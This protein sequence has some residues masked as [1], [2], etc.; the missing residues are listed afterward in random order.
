MVTIRSVNEIIQSLQDFFRLVQ[1]NLDTK[2]GTVARDLFIE[3]PASQ[4]SLLYDELSGVS[5]QQSLRLVIGSDLDRLAKNFG[6][7]RKQSTP[8]TGTALLTFTSIPANIAINQG[9]LVIANNGISFAVTA[10]IAITPA[11]SN[12]YKSVASKFSSQLSTAGITDQYAVQVTVIATS[13]GSSGNIGIYSLTRSTNTSVSNVTNVVAFSGG[14]DQESDASFRN[15]VLSSFTGSSVGTALGYLNVA[16]GVSGVSDAYVVGPGDVLMTRDGT[17]VET[18]NG[19]PTIVSEGSGGKVDIIVLGSNLTQATD[20]YIYIDQSNSNDPTNAKNNVVLGQIAADAN[21]TINQKRI[22][23]IAN[24]VLPTQPVANITSVTGSLSGSNFVAKSVDSLGRVSGNYTFTSDTGPY[25][26]SPFGFDTFSWISNKISGYPDTIIK[27]QYNGQDP[28]TFTDV[29]DITQLQQN[30]SITNENSTVTSDRS[31][32]QL[33]HTPAVNITRVLNVNTGERYLIVNQNYDNTGTYNTTGRIQISGN[34]LPS[35][36]DQL[37]VDYSWIIYYDPYSDF[38]GLVNTQNPRTV[39]DSVDWG[40]ASV[41][42]NERVNFTID[43]SNGFFNGNTTLP[44]GTVIN[45][46]TFLEINGTVTQITSGSYS[47]RMSVTIQN[48]PIATLSVDSITLKNNTTELYATAQNDGS[49]SNITTVSGIQV[50]Y[51]TTIILPSDTVATNGQSVSVILN[52]SDVFYGT[53]STGSSS[54]TEIT[55]PSSQ[56]TTTA[57]NI[58]LRV[59]YIANITD[60]FSIPTTSFPVSRVSNGLLLGSNN[61]FNNFSQVNLV[62]RENQTVQQNT[63]NQIYIEINSPATDYSLTVSQVLSVI[64]LS[65]NKELWNSSYPGSI[66]TGNDGNYQLVLTGYNTPLV[67]DKVLVIYYT[68]DIKRYQPF[69]YANY[70]INNRVD[71]LKLDLVSGLMTVPLNNFVNQ[72]TGIHFSVIEPNTDIILFS[73]TDGYLTSNLST[74]NLSS[75][76]VNFDTLPSILNKKVKITTANSAIDVGTY[77]ITGYNL[78]TNTLT[79]TNIYNNITPDQIC[80]IHV[81]DGQEIW[82]YSG[83]IDIANNRLLLPASNFTHAGDSVYIILFN[84]NVLRQAATK[85]IGTTIDQVVNVGTVTISGTTL[86]MAEDIVFTA[87]ST[88]LKQNISEAVRDVLN[89]PSTTALPSNIQLVRIAKLE[90][91]ITESPTDDSVL[92]V[93]TTFDLK[94]TTLQNNLFYPNQFLSNSSLL[95]LD[96]VLPSTANNTLTGTTQ[97]L[98]TIGD[99]LRITFYYTVNNDSEN[100]LYTRNGTLYTNKKF[101]FINKAYIASGF[102]ASQSTKFTGT[103]FTQPVLGSRYQVN[104]DYLAPKQ[105]ERIVITYNY[106]QIIT[107]ATFAVENTRPINADVLVKQAQEVLLDLTL[108]IVIADSYQSSSTTIIQNVTNQIDAVLTTTTLGQV[109]DQVTIINTAQGVTG[110]ARARI[111]YF[112]ITGVQGSIL[113]AQAQN[114]QYFTANNVIINTESR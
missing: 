69:S 47:N 8:A 52:S 74:A 34:T 80:V 36:T 64:R 51:T 17:I 82:N 24:G 54:G 44:V 55:I 62:R 83:T 85:V 30:I 112:N 108:Y 100:L 102:K 29:L 95:N 114:N 65:D 48:L 21:L 103:S 39:T 88:G 66:I 37:Q 4:I 97:N 110:V 93:S 26:G 81:S 109:V 16:L 98:P 63:S 94:N 9:D 75:I 79:I 45:A 38:D 7:I 59:T 87:T 10:G 42:N 11:N 12:F 50:L 61:G 99:K 72:A 58:I 28:L 60:L 68:F 3:G 40:Y 106:N 56:I 2:P 92:E 70:I 96:F 1:P 76:S 101:V 107:T 20:S 18:I 91:V 25:G 71:S 73:V 78:S 41:V 19:T 32:I 27:G 105:N 49:F 84:Y 89:I 86:F 77:D 14:T 43:S 113:I 31:I 67:G 46:K 33:L 57:E 53:T 6:I 5:S 23:D 90:K 22:T 104:Y 15:R 35:P 13:A 111:A